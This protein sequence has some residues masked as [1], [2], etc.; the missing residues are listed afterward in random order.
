MQNFSPMGAVENEPLVMSKKTLHSTGLILIPVIPHHWCFHCTGALTGYYWKS[1]CLL[2]S[3]SYCSQKTLH[4]CLLISNDTNSLQNKIP[5]LLKGCW[6]VNLKSHKSIAD[7]LAWGLLCCSSAN[8]FWP[9]CRLLP[10][11]DLTIL[12]LQ[13]QYYRLIHL[14]SS[15]NIV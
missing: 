10:Q 12:K 4:L 3:H 1:L 14:I 2:I 13:L 15:L 8:T 7:T 9:H 5:S 11:S 6:V